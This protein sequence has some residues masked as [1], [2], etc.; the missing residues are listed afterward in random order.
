MA[1][2]EMRGAESVGAA[3]WGPLRAR[4]SAI[5]GSPEVGCD[6]GGFCPGV[7]DWGVGG[8]EGGDTAVLFVTAN[9]PSGFGFG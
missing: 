9:F 7:W 5:V 2:C 3:G 4:E 1:N 6:A 8:D